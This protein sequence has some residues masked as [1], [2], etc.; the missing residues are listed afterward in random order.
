MRGIRRALP[1]PPDKRA[2]FVLPNINLPAS[3]FKPPSS[4]WLLFKAAVSL[5]IHALL[6]YGAFCQFSPNALT[7]VFKTG[8]ELAFCSCHGVEQHLGPNSVLGVLFTFEPKYTLSNGLGTRI[9][10]LT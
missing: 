6:R 1:A 8:R 5:G 2:A 9:C 7:L 3:Y 10:G 4:R